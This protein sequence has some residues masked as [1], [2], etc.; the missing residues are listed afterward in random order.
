MSDSSASALAPLQGRVF[1]MLWLAW[2]AAN[3]TMWTNDAA[4]A[5]LMTTLTDSTTMVALVAA[6][7]T[8]PVFLLGLPSGALADLLDR[9]LYFAST[10][11][12][13]AVVACVL[14]AVS[15]SGAMTAPLLL[16]L[17]FANGIGLALRW[18]VFAAIVPDIVPKVHLSQ[19]L[20]LNGVAMNLSRI[21]GP[22]L[23]GVVLASAGPGWVFVLNAL[24]SLVA[25][26]IILRWRSQQRRTSALP[27]ERFV[28]A[29]RVGLQHVRQS[30]PMRRVLARI[31]LFFLQ[32]AALTALL[33]LIARG[34]AGPQ[35]GA[36]LFTLLLA[37]Q[38]AGAVTAVMFFPRWRERFPPTLFVTVGPLVHAGLTLLIAFAPHPAVAALAMV[39]AG[40]AW[41]SAANTLTVSAQMVLPGW[42]RARGMSIYQMCLMG[43]TAAGAALWG[44]VAGHSSVRSA[45]VASVVAGVA[46][47]LLLRRWPL[48]SDSAPDPS[49]AQPAGGLPEPASPVDPEAGPVMVTVEYQIDPAREAAFKAVM[50]QTRQARLRQ[51]ALSWGLFQDAAAPGR[52]IEYFVDESWVEHLR[53]HERFTAGDIGLREQRLAFHLGDEPPRVRRY[54][55]AQVEP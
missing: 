22:V 43:G 52:Y 17:T 20:A 11:L 51:G 42:V 12:W 16:A 31:F 7:S 32:T 38:G 10:Q 28:G 46:V 6:A 2:L 53:R 36:H 18:P 41:I 30:P 4:A 26:V 25:F 5:W 55:D 39:L 37:C 14:A 49:P 34:L 15:L 1:R 13:V 21:V 3:I 8:L 29:M 48:I 23:A 44:Q 54:I 33:P 24:L 35:Q 9:R 47:Q 27:G 40:M 50:Q 19:A 45:L